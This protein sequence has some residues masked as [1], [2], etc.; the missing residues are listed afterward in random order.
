[1]YGGVYDPKSPR[2]DERG[3]RRDVLEALRR[4]SMPL[5]RYPG[6]NY[7]SA[8][9]WKDTV[10]PRASRP[11]R[12]DYA[13]QSVESNQF[14]IGEF[15]TWCEELGTSPFLAVNLGTGDAASA[16]QLVEYCNLPGGTHY[17]DL[18][19][20][21]GQESPYAVKLWGLGNELDGPWDTDLRRPRD[22]GQGA[23]TRPAPSGQ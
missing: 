8:Y 14:G 15:M 17:S 9:D 1:V 10:G 6:G 12:P 18:R 11:R 3:F 4:M 22:A 23:P 5:V 20:Q 7:V 21:H 16:G 2:S 19:A 13:W